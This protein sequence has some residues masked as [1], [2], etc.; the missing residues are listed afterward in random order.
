MV[1][2]AMVR[3]GSK[4]TGATWERRRNVPPRFGVCAWAGSVRPPAVAAA[5]AA[6]SCSNALRG[7]VILC[8]LASLGRIRL[9]VEPGGHHAAAVVVT[10]VGPEVLHVRLPRGHRAHR[11][12]EQEVGLLGDIALD[13][14]DQLLALGD[15]E[16][17]P[18]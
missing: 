6:P 5:A 15:I 14:V 11:R 13:V 1:A 10:D 4:C 2:K 16:R 8:P 9:L 17:A 12:A 7:M 18:L 3:C